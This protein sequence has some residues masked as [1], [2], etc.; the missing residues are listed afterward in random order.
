MY[1]AQIS[2]NAVT[3]MVGSYIKVLTCILFL[4]YFPPNTPREPLE[5]LLFLT[6]KIS[7]TGLKA[8]VVYR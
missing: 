4:K 7:V 6:E 5:L 3:Y 1:M 2:K 8:E